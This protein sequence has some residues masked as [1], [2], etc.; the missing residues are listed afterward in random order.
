MHLQL[1]LL[2]GTDITVLRM[3]TGK[4]L[5]LTESVVIARGDGS[6]VAPGNPF[7]VGI[8]SSAAPL[9]V[10]RTPAASAYLT[11]V[12]VNQSAQGDLT[13]V[14][15]VVGKT[16]R[17]YRVF[18]MSAVAGMLTP[19]DGATAFCGPLPF[20]ANG[21]L[22]MDYDGEPWFTCTLGNAF[23]MNMSAAGQLSGR[24]GYTVT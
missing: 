16:I 22:I 11:Q 17:V 15:A 3:Q 9:Q 12:G 20:S 24:I 21:G 19:K 10:V 14:P 4:G 2:C 5:T 7:P 23:V 8:D 18:L 13:L 1:P 6:L